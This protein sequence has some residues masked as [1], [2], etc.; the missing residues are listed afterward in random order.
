MASKI[1][2]SQP[3]RLN[4]YLAQWGD[5]SRRKADALIKRGEVFINGS[6]VKNLGVLIDSQKDQVRIKNRIIHKQNFSPVYIMLNKP[7]NV[8]TTTADPKDRT[9]VMDF[10][11]KHKQR[12]FPIGRLD[13][14]SEGLLL[15]T[16]DGDFA[17]K[18]LHPKNKISKTYLVKVQGNPSQGQLRKLVTGVSTPLGRMRALHAEKTLKTKQ[19]N[20]WIKV[21]ISEGKNRQI[22]HMF[23]KLGYRINKLRRVSIGRL[24]LSKLKKGS[25]VLLKKSDAEKAFLDPKE[26]G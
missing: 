4:K 5:I 17:Q 10:I 13:W 8:L 9:T 19:N 14:K 1:K 25:Y 6:K 22:R 26:L 2:A 16:N 3:I 20:Q 11:K 23:N 24:K 7:E 18:I 12:I 15:L 21:I